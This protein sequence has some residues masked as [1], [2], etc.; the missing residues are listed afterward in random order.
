M[1]KK[2][3][4]KRKSAKKSSG[5]KMKKDCRTSKERKED[6]GQIRVQNKKT[7]VWKWVS[8]AKH[9]D[10]KARYKTNTHLQNWVKAKQTVQSETNEVLVGAKIKANPPTKWYKKIREEYDRLESS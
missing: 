9:K 3:A 5:R 10:A 4:H 6:R 1:G 7:K 2:I 8:A